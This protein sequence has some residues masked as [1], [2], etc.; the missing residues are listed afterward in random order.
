MEL[1]VGLIVLACA[2]VLVGVVLR[3]GAAVT[4]AAV[5]LTNATLGGRDLDED[6][7]RHRASRAE[8]I[9]RPKSLAGIRIP[10]PGVGYAVLLNIVSAVAAAACQ[11]AATFGAVAFL[12]MTAPAVTEEFDLAAVTA[13]LGLIAVSV[14]AGLIAT[15]VVLKMALPTTFVRAGVV[16]AWQH[17][18]CVLICVVLLVPVF[19]FGVADGTRAPTRPASG[20]WV[21]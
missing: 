19:V 9:P 20:A 18:I 21:R 16:V 1:I 17:V 12:G 4:R 7:F 10:V 15:M 6:D 11:G 13:G 5:R 2:G 14:G 3:I 8:S